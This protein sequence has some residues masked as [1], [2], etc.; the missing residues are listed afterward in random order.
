MTEIIE[1][2]IFAIVGI[3]AIVAV[4]ALWRI[5]TWVRNV[6]YSIEDIGMETVWRAADA[7]LRHWH[8]L[9]DRSGNNDDLMK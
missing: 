9:H 2:I 4:V 5:G 8:S 7:E 6:Y 1:N 3:V